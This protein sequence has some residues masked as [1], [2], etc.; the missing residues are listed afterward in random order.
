M[1]K[2]IKNFEEWLI[3]NFTKTWEPKTYLT[4]KKIEH[5]RKIESL[6]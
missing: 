4:L 5:M 6:T 2:L 3:S 1:T